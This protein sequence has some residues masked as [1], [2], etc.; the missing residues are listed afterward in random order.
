MPRKTSAASRSRARDRNSPRYSNGVLVCD[1][2]GL[3]FSLAPSGER[4]DPTGANEKKRAKIAAGRNL[5]LLLRQTN[6]SGVSA[7]CN[8]D[9]WF[10]IGSIR[11]N[12]SPRWK[13]LGKCKLP[14]KWYE[15]RFFEFAF[16]ATGD[17]LVIYVNGRKA[18]KVR[19]DLSVEDRGV[20]GLGTSG[21]QGSF[22][23]IEIQILDKPAAT[24]NAP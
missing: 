3:E 2:C 15:G 12:R 24:P 8:G 6:G 4:C 9:G 13:S 23:N 19:N 22:R 17:S 7:W 11:R 16:A 21:C 1:N 14:E 5:S 18:L 20:I 10:G